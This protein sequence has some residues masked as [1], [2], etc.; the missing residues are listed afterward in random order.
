L[1]L[2]RLTTALN[3]PDEDQ[4]VGLRLGQKHAQKAAQGRWWPVQN[5]KLAEL[6]AA[7]G[8]GA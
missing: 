6:R 4:E 3:L 2:E 5:G 1:L 8:Q 7:S